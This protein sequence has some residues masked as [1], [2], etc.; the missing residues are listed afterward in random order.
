MKIARIEMLLLVWT[1][2]VLFLFFVYGMRR[3]RRILKRFAS[4]RGLDAI[5]PGRA[6]GLR[7][8]KAALILISLFFV[9][10]ALSGPQYGFRWQEIERRGIDIVIALDCSKSMLARDIPP[11]RLDRAKREVYDLLGL[12]QGDRIGL[13]AFAGTAFLQCPLTLDYGAFHLFLETL[14]PAYLPVGGSDVGAAISTA[15][16]AFDDRGSREKAVI[17]ITD[18]E[19]T[20]AGDPLAEAADARAAGVTLF[21]IGVG[22]GEGVPVPDPDGG[23]MKDRRGK[24]VVSRLDE[25]TLR[26]AALATGGAYVRSTA[27]D[28]DLDVIYTQEIRGR[29]TME[30]LEGGR[31]QVW[32]DR[33]QWLL[34]LAAAALILELCLPSAAH[35]GVRMLLVFLVLSMA[36]P[37]HADALREGVSAY[38]KGSYEAALKHFIDAQLEAP[39]DPEILYN[40]GNAYYRMADYDAAARHYEGAAAAEDPRLR[41]DALFNLGNANVRRQDFQEAIE[42][43][44][45]VLKTTPDDREASENLAYARRMAELQKQEAPPGG[46]GESKEP[47]AGKDEAAGKDGAPEKDEGGEKKADGGPRSRDGDSGAK[48]APTPESGVG[49]EASEPRAAQEEGSGEREA[50]AGQKMPPSGRP[51]PSETA[52][53]PAS[54]EE[55]AGGNGLSKNSSETKR[56][57]SGTGGNEAGGESNQAERMLNR[58]QDAPGRAL[59]P[60][61]GKR[62][63]EQDW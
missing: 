32:E 63:V 22:T 39:E 3:R 2:P 40:I 5:V 60:G 24:I 34:L 12:L 19:N 50:S 6:E 29:M 21:C 10:V 35:R 27:G 52:A 42:N 8:R 37:A 53:P 47:S 57:A 49:E 41:Q 18:G 7:W 11:S 36:A 30:A 48:E 9:A 20:G 62:R 17:L 58:L 16:S 44:E 55:E 51:Q 13:V 56:G 15:V 61:T 46:A 43:Y 4:E 31:K 38:E 14:T 28:M 45:A 1:L 26:K 23:F 25:K 33:Y 54:A 59:M